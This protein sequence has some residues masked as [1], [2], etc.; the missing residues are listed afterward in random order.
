MEKLFEEQYDE[1]E[2]TI[3]KYCDLLKVATAD[4]ITDRESFVKVP[5]D[6]LD[7]SQ[8]IFVREQVLAKLI[9]AN[10][11]LQ[12][13]N[14]NLR[15]VVL[16]G[17]RSLLRQREQFDEVLKTIR[18][19]KKADKMSQLEKAHKM[20]AVPEVA[21]HPTGGAVDVCIFD[22]LKN[23]MLNFGTGWKEYEAGR[24][25]YTFS[26]E[27]D[28]EALSNRLLL[29]QIMQ[30]EGFYQFP[31]EWWHFSFGDREWA[32]ANNLAKA[33]YNQVELEK[34]YSRD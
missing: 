33:L 11:F 28:V 32:A 20:I 21:G 31:G 8:E 4:K 1:I 26:P 29:R 9:S 16:E 18:K 30:Q 17:Y 13:F 6:M 22:R 27:I 12:G 15:L 34:A 24:K 3:F 7:G 19:R 23:Q 25:N 2:K 10:N 5:D 14:S